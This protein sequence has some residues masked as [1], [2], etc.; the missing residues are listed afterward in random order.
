MKRW[1]RKKSKPVPGQGDWWKAIA[2]T[3]RFTTPDGSVYRMFQVDKTIRGTVI[4]LEL[5][6]HGQSTLKYIMNRK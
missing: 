3:T 1:A 6:E 4:S 2:E 5:D